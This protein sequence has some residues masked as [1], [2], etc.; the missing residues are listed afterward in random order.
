MFS[1]K[2]ASL[3]LFALAALAAASSVPVAPAEAAKKVKPTVTCDDLTVAAGES[4]DLVATVTTPEG[5]PIPG[6]SVF[7]R[8]RG[9]DKLVVSVPVKTDDEG[10]ATFTY[11][12]LGE[13]RP[14]KMSQTIRYSAKVAVNREYSAR[15]ASGTLTVLVPEEEEAVEEDAWEESE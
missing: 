13:V 4:V 6:L 5:D 2:R 10:V 7:M 15:S 3:S 8:I 11:K 14:G 9:L 12:A 1:M